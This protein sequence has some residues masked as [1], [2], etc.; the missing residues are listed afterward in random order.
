MLSI[1]LTLL[2]L[3]GV[4]HAVHAV[5]RV[6]TSQGAIA[7][8]VLLVVLPYVAIPLYWIFGRNKFQGY[9][10]ARRAH[11]LP[12][13]RLL[14][15]ADELIKRFYAVKPDDGLWRILT[16]L[17]GGH[18][19]H[20]NCV[21][22]LVDG[23]KTFHGMLDAIHEAN[24][25]IIFQFFIVHSDR[26]GLLF[27]SALMEKAR[28]GIRVFFL[29]D[30]FGSRKLSR[31]YLSSLEEAG[32]RVMAFGTRRGKGNRFQLNFR[33]H[34]KL[35]IVDGHTAFVGGLNLGDEYLGMSRRFGNWRD[36]HLRLSGPA[37]LSLQCAFVRDWYWATSQIPV[38]NWDVRAVEFGTDVMTISSGPADTL[39]TC[40]MMFVALINRA[41]ERLWITSP[42]FVPDPPVVSALQL[43]AL[44]GVDVRIL[45][46]EKPDHLLVYLSSFSFYA[47]MHAAGVRIFRYQPGFLHQKVMVVDSE[48][49]VVGTANLD[50][51]SFR[52]NFETSVIVNEAEFSGQVAEMLKHDFGDAREV[53]AGELN[54]RPFWF[55]AAVSISRLLSPVQ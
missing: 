14:D 12:I 24:D 31:R 17:T 51:R 48:L 26:I 30:E 21:S 42:Y 40:A 1:T 28:A 16:G 10:R 3:T 47:E 15:E 44:R 39:E 6:R 52:L 25:Y 11:S 2:H 4:L 8:A 55:R 37:L 9:V 53:E 35:V 54:S 27:Q 33:N 45:L 50:N 23:D 36:T 38:L 32:V 19:L 20:G 29:Y 34:R 13:G 22:L 41:Q 18:L 5:M 7:W 43:A 46:P 49:A